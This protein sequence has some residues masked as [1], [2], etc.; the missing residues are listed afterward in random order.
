VPIEEEEERQFCAWRG[1]GTVASK[2]LMENTSSLVSEVQVPVC[3]DDI[4]Y[5][6]LWLG[7]T[8]C[9]TLYSTQNKAK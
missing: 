7:Y 3:E 5:V 8:P 4:V 1:T 6:V 9:K 2:A